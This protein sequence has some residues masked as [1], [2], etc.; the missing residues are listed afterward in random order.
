[1]NDFGLPAETFYNATSA[2]SS[3]DDASL[4]ASLLQR[5]SSYDAAAT[6]AATFWQVLQFLAATLPIW[7]G[8]ALVG[9]LLPRPGFLREWQ[10]A[11]VKKLTGKGGRVT[12]LDAIHV[13]ATGAL[14]P[15]GP[16]SPV[17]DA[18]DN[19]FVTRDDLTFL[20]Q[21]IEQEVPLPGAS[22][23]QLMMEKEIPGVVM[24]QAFKR[25]L[26]NGTTEYKSTTV[27]NDA[28]ANEITDFY[29]DD[30]HR[31]SYDFVRTYETIEQGD[32]E[33]QEQVVRWVRKYPFAFLSDRE[34]VMAR[35]VFVEQPGQL[36]YGLMKA[37]SHP[38][39]PVKPDIVRVDVCWSMWRARTVRSPWGGADIACETTLLHHEEVKIPEN[40]AKFAIS[41]GMWSFVKKMATATRSFIED[42][43][44]H[45]AAQ[46]ADPA[47]YS[48]RAPDTE[49]PAPSEVDAEVLSQ[50]RRAMMD[51]TL[52][53]VTVATSAVAP[54]APSKASLA[55]D[56]P[57]TSNGLAA[58]LTLQQPSQL[59]MLVK[60]RGE[61]RR[62]K[63]GVNIEELGAAK[64]VAGLLLGGLCTFLVMHLAGGKDGVALSRRRRDNNRGGQWRSGSGSSSSS[65]DNEG[66]GPVSRPLS[67]EDICEAE[68]EMAQ[69]SGDDDGGEVSSEPV[70]EAPAV[71]RDWQ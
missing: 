15:S 49:P 11:T 67:D 36:V 63:R 2:P 70:S 48:R 9:V 68:Q 47:A 43:R 66:R 38:M 61:R 4:F 7:L 1:M 56:V 55:S 34:F 19:W 52:S 17:A 64:V 51:R 39:V 26:P 60:Q 23:W 59:D 8:G 14:T 6:A 21:H 41:C 5:L 53:G 42:R 28:S 40:L 35:R 13:D 44:T 32:S 71:A 24:Y 50:H 31:P 46:E 54:R 37:I 45:T 3:S 30:R 20:K 58:R 18:P 22:K 33:Q 69:L 25:S 57:T 65:G 29:L 10:Q 27:T 16:A 62:R 12:S